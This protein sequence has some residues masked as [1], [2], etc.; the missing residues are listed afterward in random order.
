MGKLNKDNLRKTVYYLKKNG[1]RNTMYAVAERLQPKETDSYTYKEP[2]EDVLDRQR[3]TTWENPV[4]FSILVPVYHTPAEY[5]KEMVE[6]VLQQT[7]PYFQLILLD[8][9]EEPEPLKTL[10]EEYQDDR[11]CYYKL[12]DNKG[13]AE[14]TNAGIPYAT[15][16]YIAL[17]DHDDLLTADALYEFATAIEEGKKQGIDYQM[18]Y[19]DE[20]KCDG[21]GKSFYEPHFKLD[22]DLDL[23]MT[24]NYICHFTA[25][26]ADVFKELQLRGEYNGAQD[27]D[28][29]L[30]VAGRFMSAPQV[31]CHVPKVLYHW[32]CHRNS[33]AANPASKMYAY[34]AGKRAVESFVTERGWNASVEHLKH[35]GFYR[36]NY[37]G[38][39]FKQRPEVGALG[40]SL[41]GPKGRIVGGLR[42]ADGALVYEGLKHGFSGYMN[43]AALVQQAEVLDIRCM[44]IN[45]ACRELLEQCLQEYGLTMAEFQQLHIPRKD[46]DI[47]A[48]SVKV[49]KTLKE[50][51]YVLVWDPW[52][53]QLHSGE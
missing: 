18:I 27:F 26:K 19:S 30:R 6:S 7:Y 40:G 37:E 13:I 51:G 47:K 33:T 24:N 15:G 32:R 21:D 1:I 8:A 14:N 17:L 39:I 45:P 48:L 43:R 12:D 34:E 52:W 42:T 16:D 5:F 46:I 4:T 23:L 44:N 50:A 2:A 25:I 29:V 38:D 3:K 36:V 49:S 41:L 22:F 31:I 10:A 35:L 11:V 9:G 28:L 20:D 53:E